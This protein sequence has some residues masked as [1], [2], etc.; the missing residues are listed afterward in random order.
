M[1]CDQHVKLERTLAVLEERT[2]LIL[3]T[4]EHLEARQAKLTQT[5]A[6]WAGVG[7]VMLSGAMVAFKMLVDAVM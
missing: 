5:V 1:Q 2:R 7:V 4:V 3:L 6:K